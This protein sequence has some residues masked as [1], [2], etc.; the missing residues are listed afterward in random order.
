[1]QASVAD[2]PASHY[3]VGW[4]AWASFTK[5]VDQSPF[6]SSSNVPRF[7]SFALPVAIAMATWFCVDRD[8]F[9]LTLPQFAV[10]FRSGV[11]FHLN[12]ANHDASFRVSPPADAYGSGGSTSFSRHRKHSVQEQTS[13][14]SRLNSLLRGFRSFPVLV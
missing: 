14:Y 3:N 5:V 1:M 8:T 13:V 7:D 9:R 10:A 11:A 6:L 4:R 12:M 2:S